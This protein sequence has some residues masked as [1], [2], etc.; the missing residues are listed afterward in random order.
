MARPVVEPCPRLST[1]FCLLPSTLSTAGPSIDQCRAGTPTFTF[2][3]G[4]LPKVFDWLT[5]KMGS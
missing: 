2:G 3:V 4:P 5:D 1:M